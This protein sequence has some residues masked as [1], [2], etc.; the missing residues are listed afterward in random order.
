M[1]SRRLIGVALLLFKITLHSVLWTLKIKVTTDKLFFF[2][3]CFSLYIFEKH[4]QTEATENAKKCQPQT[5]LD[6]KPWSL[7]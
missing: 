6:T 4:Q 5:G 7:M 1:L 2:V 3:F